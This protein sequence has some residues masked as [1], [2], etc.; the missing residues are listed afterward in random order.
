MFLGFSSM[1]AGSEGGLPEEDRV[2]QTNE[3]LFLDP[4]PTSRRHGRV[5]R[6]RPASGGHLFTDSDEGEKPVIRDT[7]FSPLQPE[8]AM[9]GD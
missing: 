8:P 6:S 3:F 1:T 5:L 2:I 7:A 4:S 9:G